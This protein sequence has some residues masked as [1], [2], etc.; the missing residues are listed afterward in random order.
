ALVKGQIE[1]ELL[2]GDPIARAGAV[3]FEASEQGRFAETFLRP[4]HTSGGSTLV[5]IRIST[6]RTHQIRVHLSSAGFPIVGDL[7]YGGVAAPRMMLHAWKLAHPSV[8][9]WTAEPPEGMRGEG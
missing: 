7:K 5:E 3:R 9:A 8:G 1:E 2:L 6:G 4:L